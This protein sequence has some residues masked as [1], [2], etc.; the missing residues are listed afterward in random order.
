MLNFAN[1]N[2]DIK[3]LHKRENDSS[4]ILSF[5]IFR[6]FFLLINFLHQSI[7]VFPFISLISCLLFAICVYRRYLNFK[8]I[9]VHIVIFAIFLIRIR[10]VKEK[11]RFIYFIINLI[12]K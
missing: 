11:L 10:K 6:S 4:G 7:S 1:I 9:I 5:S 2:R 12:I 8:L 3:Y